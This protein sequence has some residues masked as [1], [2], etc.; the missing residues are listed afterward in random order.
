VAG[1]CRRFSLS[2]YRRYSC[3]PRSLLS[4]FCGG[5]TPDSL[6]GD[7]LSAAGQPVE[8]F[9]PSHKYST[10][11]R[12]LDDFDTAIKLRR[13]AVQLTTFTYVVCLQHALTVQQCTERR[14]RFV[15]SQ[16]NSDFHTR[17]VNAPNGSST[18]NA[19]PANKGRERSKTNRHY[20][21]MSVGK[22]PGL[23]NAGAE[24]AEPSLLCDFLT[25]LSCPVLFSRERS[26]CT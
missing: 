6:A 9:S 20:W 22:F 13:G 25:V 16:A 21:K 7:G 14:P 3:R 8:C 15:F 19:R 5:R 10:C 11:D 26:R 2:V 1:T 12:R 23:T 18:E 24:N 17:T 4:E